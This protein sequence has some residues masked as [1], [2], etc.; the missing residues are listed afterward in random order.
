VHREGTLRVTDHAKLS[1]LAFLSAAMFVENFAAFVRFAFPMMR[2]CAHHPSLRSRTEATSLSDA[3]KISLS[4]PLKSLEWLSSMPLAEAKVSHRS[5]LQ[6]W[7]W[8]VYLEL[9]SA[10]VSWKAFNSVT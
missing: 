5:P 9:A 6:P 8:R 7:C 4:S 3:V 2:H 10:G 1:H